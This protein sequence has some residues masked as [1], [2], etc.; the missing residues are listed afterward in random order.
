MPNGKSRPVTAHDALE[1]I[2][3][4]VKPGTLGAKMREYY[5]STTDKALTRL[6]YA[7]EDAA[8]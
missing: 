6:I 5:I 7:V 8:E 3:D 1:S 4:D 2:I